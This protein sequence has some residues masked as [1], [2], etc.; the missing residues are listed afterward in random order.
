[1]Y[2][3]IN[4]GFGI[5]VI[6]IYSRREL[7]WTFFLL[8]WKSDIRFDTKC[9]IL[10]FLWYYLSRLETCVCVT[11]AIQLFVHG[12]ILSISNEETISSNFCFR[13]TRK[14]WRILYKKRCSDHETYV[15]KATC[16]TAV[17][18]IHH[19]NSMWCFPL[20]HVIR[21]IATTIPKQ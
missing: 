13:I 21:P 19:T 3:M 5:S 10:R 15:F 17:K 1:M 9:L 6:T 8:Y 18:K 4:V 2:S 11:M 12:S 14:S 20:N 16:V 7:G